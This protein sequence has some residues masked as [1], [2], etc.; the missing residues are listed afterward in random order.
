MYFYIDSATYRAP[1]IG[2]EREVKTLKKALKSPEAELIA[3]LGRR[4]VGKTYLVREFFKGQI[5]FE[6]V[7]LPDG[8]K[9]EQLRNFS[10]SLQ[11]AQNSADQPEV[12]RDWLEAF[13]QLQAY[14]EGLGKTPHKKVV[15]IDEFPW[16]ATSRSGFMTGFS[17][18]WNSYASKANIIV[19]ICGSAT[20]WM[21]E[22]VVHNKKGLHNRVTQL[23]A[24]QPFTLSETKAYFN[25]RGV[26]L[27]HYQ[28]VQLYMAMGG[29]P[30]YLKQVEPGKSAVQNIDDICFQPDGILRTEFR[31]LYASLF[32][33]PENYESIVRALAGNWKGMNRAEIVAATGLPDG[34]TLSRMLKELVQSGFLSS[35]IPFD[36]K[37]KDTIYR[38]SDNYSLFYLKFVENLA[39]G[40]AGNWKSLSTTQSWISWSGYAFENICL[41]HVDKIK[42][43]LGISGIESRE[44]S[45]YSKGNADLEGVQIDLLIDRADNV[46]S[47]CEMKFYKEEFLLSKTYA[48]EMRR[49][50]TLLR[51]LTKTKK[52]IFL[53]L[54]TTFG[55]I[56]GKH[57]VGLIDN[58]VTMDDLF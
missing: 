49:K 9:R 50:R 26:L 53:V 20:S 5:D 2:R 39:S 22:K 57:S 24:L 52:Q 25:S 47:L 51:N 48:E 34:G 15:F 19:I 41:Q 33:H 10:Y 37:K 46:I 55:L 44:F 12:P 28:I 4:R 43:T 42:E 54:I 3:L 31:N 18:F 27:D 23:L 16:V 40:V 30:H 45:Y 29:I 58:T 8:S 38:L 17:Y 36:K 21:I 13:H 56:P 14:L 11:Q 7:G 1:M 32:T 35:Y 6:M